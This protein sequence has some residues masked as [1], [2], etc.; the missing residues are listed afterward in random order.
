M[1]ALG[2]PLITVEIHHD[3]LYEN[4]SL[5]CEMFSK[6]AGYSEEYLVFDSDL[7]KDNKG[8]KLDE[9]F[10]ITPSFNKVIDPTV[11]TVYVAN[12]SIPATT[13]S[14]SSSLSSSSSVKAIQ[15]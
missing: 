3:Q 12:T 8:L 15:K 14:A 9:L 2:A 11:P 6:F 10:S 7:Y 1:R 13:F 4:I 5:A